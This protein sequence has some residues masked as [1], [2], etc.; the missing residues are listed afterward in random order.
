M[1]CVV[2]QCVIDMH[3]LNGALFLDTYFLFLL[4]A[5]LVPSAVIV[6]FTIIYASV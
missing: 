4:L 5:T 1:L 3:D 2:Y 6:S